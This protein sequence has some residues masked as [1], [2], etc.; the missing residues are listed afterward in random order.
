MQIDE[1]RQIA[2]KNN[3]YFAQNDEL[4]NDIRQSVDVSKFVGYITNIERGYRRMGRA[5]N[6]RIEQMTQK[7][8]W[9]MQLMIAIILA[10]LG[11]LS[12]LYLRDASQ[13]EGLNI[14][15]LAMAVILCAGVPALLHK[16]IERPLTKLNVMIVI[17]LAVIMVI[18]AA[19]TLIV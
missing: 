8:F 13:T 15:G 11:S 19:V 5:I 14:M 18:Y 3:M 10:V 12:I 9:A 1:T 6:S 2:Q 16:W 17:V 7:T 4:K